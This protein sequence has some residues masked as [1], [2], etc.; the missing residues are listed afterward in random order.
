MSLGWMGHQG[1]ECSYP[2]LLG[3]QADGERAKVLFVC[4][5]GVT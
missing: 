2:Y 1:M 3:C 5:R 4:V